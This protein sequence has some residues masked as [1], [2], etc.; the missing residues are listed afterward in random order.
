M[1]MLMRIQPENYCKSIELTLAVRKNWLSPMNAELRRKSKF[2]DCF[3]DEK[4]RA[5]VI[6]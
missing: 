1:E 6:A 4:T 2:E 3:V 5:P